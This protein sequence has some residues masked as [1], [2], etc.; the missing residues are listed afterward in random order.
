[1]DVTAL[2]LAIASLAAIIA[3]GYVYGLWIKFCAYMFG[4]IAGLFLS[5]SPMCLFLVLVLYAGFAGII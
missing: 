1:M 4:E 5:M 2:L 3:G